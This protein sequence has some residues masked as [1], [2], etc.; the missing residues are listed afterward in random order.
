[1]SQQDETL[2]RALRGDG[3]P[4]ATADGRYTAREIAER[5]GLCKDSATKHIKAAVERGT[6]RCVGT[7]RVPR[8]DGVMASIPTYEVVSNG[9]GV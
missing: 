6:L 1:M 8:V 9:E 3:E 5:L 2:L 4:E 7:R